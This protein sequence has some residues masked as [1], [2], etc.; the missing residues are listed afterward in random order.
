MDWDNL[1]LWFKVTALIEEKDFEGANELLDDMIAQDPDNVHLIFAKSISYTISGPTK[2]TA[3]STNEIFPASYCHSSSSQFQK[4]KM[5]CLD[6]MYRKEAVN[7][8]I[9]FFA[10][11][12]CAAHVRAFP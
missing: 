3:S 1:Q 7:K 11:S 9:S 8:R 2:I 4:Q 12:S 6:L 5:Y 10:A